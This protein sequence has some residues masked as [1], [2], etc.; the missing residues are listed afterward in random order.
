MGNLTLD[1]CIGGGQ[2][3]VFD[4]RKTIENVRDIVNA[5]TL[6]LML[7]LGFVSIF[8]SFCRLDGSKF[9]LVLDPNWIF[10]LAGII[11]STASVLLFAFTREIEIRR[12]K[13]HDGISLKFGPFLAN[14]E[15]F[16]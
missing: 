1:E 16:P 4:V 2:K 8:V 12:I 7:L 14:P 13:I 5:P 6:N 10:L 3:A 9:W 15:T 11:S